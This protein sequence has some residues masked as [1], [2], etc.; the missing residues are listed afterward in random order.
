MRYLI[1][2]IFA[3]ALTGCGKKEI[4]QPPTA[5]ALLVKKLFNNLAKKEHEAAVKR[6]EKVRALDTSN[7][8][9]L[10]LEEREFCNHYIKQ[11][12]KQLD[13]NNIPKAISIISIAREKYPLNLNL[14][15][16][17]T[18][19]DQ[20]SKLQ[21]HIKILNSAS[22]SRKMNTQINAIAMFIKKYPAGKVLRPLLRKKILLAFKQKLYE[23][24]RSR[25]DLLCDIKTA[26][27]AA[28]PDQSL[29]ST[30]L[31]ILARSNAST[32]NKKERIKA[33]LLD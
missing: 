30:L 21:K 16:I 14:L 26:H 32:V 5:H 8:F 3:I 31:A 29:N 1:I 25:F 33:N 4:P 24:Q 23:Q 2:F 9:L 27:S 15:A 11:A 18:E 22:S 12:Q 10:Q 17:N 7:E 13:A 6:I 28:T 20:L 19:L